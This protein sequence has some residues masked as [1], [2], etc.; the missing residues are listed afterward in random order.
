MPRRHRPIGDTPVTMQKTLCTGCLHSMNR[1]FEPSSD[2]APNPECV[3]DA[4]ASILCRLCSKMRRPCDD[5]KSTFKKRL[6]AITLGLTKGFEAA[7]TANRKVVGP[8]T[9]KEAEDFFFFI[10][11]DYESEESKWPPIL[12]EIQELLNRVLWETRRGMER[13]PPPPV[14][15]R[16]HQRPYHPPDRGVLLRSRLT[17]PD[18]SRRI[19][20]RDVPVRIS[21]SLKW[22][23]QAGPLAHAESPRGELDTQAVTILQGPQSIS[24]QEATNQAQNLLR[25]RFPRTDLKVIAG[26][27]LYEKAVMGNGF[28]AV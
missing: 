12:D 10:G 27:N 16:F 25:P 18:V 13:Y 28:C 6:S 2:A 19:R 22:T 11:A 1:S 14:V 17:V 4:Q 8:G 9:G 15:S 26:I 3:F 5:V 24:Q 21:E 7:E 23:R 20:R